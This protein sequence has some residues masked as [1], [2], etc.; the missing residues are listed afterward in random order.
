MTNLENIR[1]LLAEA[2]EEINNIEYYC[3]AEIVGDDAR[4]LL[5]DI[6]AAR[7][8]L[9]WIKPEDLKESYQVKPLYDRLK[10]VRTS[11]R[12]LRNTLDRADASVEKALDRCGDISSSIEVRQSPDDDEL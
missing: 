11:L 7:K 9:F 8:E 4:H 1:R 12:V 3:D 6:V 2:L 10:S 5:A